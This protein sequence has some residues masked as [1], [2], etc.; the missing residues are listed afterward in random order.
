MIE[1]NVEDYCHYCE[2]FD[3]EIKK[4]NHDDIDVVCKRRIWC[5]NAIKLYERTKKEEKIDD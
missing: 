4:I 1:L 3:P 2:G 5:K